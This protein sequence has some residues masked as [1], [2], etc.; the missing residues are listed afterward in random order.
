M[1]D[2]RADGRSD[3][4]GGVLD[5]QTGGRA[6]APMA[7]DALSQSLVGN[8]MPPSFPLPSI[9][10]LHPPDCTPLLFVSRPPLP[11]LSVHSSQQLN[12]GRRMED[13]D[14]ARLVEIK[15]TR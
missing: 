1:C 8:A 11:H 5:G 9:P 10:M 12:T 14:C 13:G 4:A 7:H 2:G 3:K 6:P 15:A